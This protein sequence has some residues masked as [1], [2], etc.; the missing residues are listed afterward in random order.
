[1]L[2]VTQ[3]CPTLCN[4]MNCSPS[5]SSV[6]APYV[7]SS[8]KNTGASWH[9]L[10]QG[11]LPTQGKNSCLLCLHLY[12]KNSLPLNHL[13]SP[14]FFDSS[15]YLQTG[16]Q[17]GAGSSQEPSLRQLE[18]M[19]VFVKNPSAVVWMESFCARVLYKISI[20]WSISLLIF[21]LLV[22]SIIG[23][24]VFTFSSKIVN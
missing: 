12:Q 10:F 13:G 17:K 24:L 3:S 18:T 4:S 2:I 19:P 8:R 20:M 21:C 5:G 14:K 6:H 9:F 11:I 16:I 1:M 15:N 23:R 22:L 7:H